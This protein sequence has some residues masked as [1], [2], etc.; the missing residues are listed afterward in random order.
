M[1]KNIDNLCFE[2]QNN[3]ESGHRCPTCA[4]IRIEHKVARKCISALLEA[5]YELSVYDGE[6]M[7]LENSKD[8]KAVFAAMFSTDED[9]LYAFQVGKPHS[10][11]RFIYGNSGYDVISDYGVSL[12]NVLAPV[13]DYAESLD[14]FA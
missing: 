13:N 1:A 4:R 6:D 9:T 3:P 5:G 12:E 7:A 10:F 11:V 2:H 8:T 14:R